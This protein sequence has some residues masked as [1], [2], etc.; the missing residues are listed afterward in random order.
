MNKLFALLFCGVLIFHSINLSAQQIFS[1]EDIIERTTSSSPYAKREET[2]KENRY[3][4]YRYFRTN[5]NP[6]LRL[7]GSIP[8]YYKIVQQVPQPDGTFRYLSV[9]QTDNNLNLGLIQ[10]IA[11]T[12]GTIS[13][14]TSLAYFK[15]F[16]A[17]NEV[18]GEQWSGTVMNV[19]LS[20]P[21]FSFNSLRWDRR[22][23]PL[24]YEE[25][26]RDYVEQMEFASRLAVES[27]FNV[28]QQQVNLQIATF[29]LANNDTI[30]K[31]EQ[32]RY[33]IGTTSL[34]KLLQV[35][36]Q[37]LRSRQDVAQANLDL[38]TA[39]L[40]LRTF[41]GL[42]DDDEFRLIMPEIIPL[43]DVSIDDALMYAK[44]NRAA[45]IAFERRRLEA[46]REVAEARGQRFQTTL[47]A[48]Y[49]LNNNGLIMDDVYKNPTQQQQ[50]NLAISVPVLDWGRN[51]SRM[52]TA[53]ANK[54]LNDYIIAQD[55]VNFEQEVVTQVRQFEMLRLQI[56]ITKK[57]DEV[58]AERYNVAQNRYLIGKIDITN[59]NI[60]LTEKDAAKQ[61]YIQALKSF[62]IAY[63]ELRRLTLY[64]FA[65]KQL[66]YKPDNG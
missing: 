51:K 60:A 6:Q 47:T 20:Q 22:T 24:R 18:L 7:Q 21:I 37:L 34:D 42:N 9:E 62:W 61:S 16:Q 4:Q 31:I 56:E 46:E 38:Q 3:W 13:A 10:P 40:Q 41:I 11:L 17:L 25:S 59:L 2:R 65:N 50:F 63:Y 14:N 32:G 36:L 54:K 33:N 5:Y 30:Y 58:A 26:K 15:D 12:G 8:A 43:F 55:E 29:N 23:E 49:G 57:S 39:R 52:Q 53:I 44:Q 35:E 28:L 48:A 19:A 64:D 45:Y 66:L 27:F 1:I